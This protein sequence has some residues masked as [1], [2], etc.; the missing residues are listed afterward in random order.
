LTWKIFAA[1]QH[2]ERAGAGNAVGDEMVTK[3]EG[4]EIIMNLLNERPLSLTLSAWKS[5]FVLASR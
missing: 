4:E 2:E 5:L 1:W 3:L